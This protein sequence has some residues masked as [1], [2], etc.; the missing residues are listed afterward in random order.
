MGIRGVR[1]YVDGIP[2]TM[3]DGQGQISNVDLGSAAA[4][5]VLRGPFSALYGNSSGGVLQVFTEDGTGRS[6]LTLGIE[7]GSDGQLHYDSKLVGAQAG[8]DYVLSASHFET[9]GYREHSAARRDI[10]NAKLGIQLDDDSKLTV[11]ANA[12]QLP[13]AQD[14]MGLTRQELKGDPRGVDPSAVQFNTRKSLSQTQGG[15]IYERHFG[16]DNTLRALV[17]GGHRDTEQFQSIPAASQVN[18]LSPGGVIQ[19]GRDY[20]GTDVRWT[21]EIT[22]GTQR[23]SLVGRLAYDKLRE[24]RL[25]YQND[26]GTGSAQQLGLQGALRRDEINDVTDLDPY[27][28]VEWHPGAAWT[29][30][31]GVRHSRVRFISHDA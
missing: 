14:P 29:L 3:P 19:L 30:D 4:I 15:L 28:Q 23:W 11:V 6:K 17:Y 27:A 31:A 9:K 21:T 2:A 7:A 8:L 13:F 16:A 5:E 20:D 18:P 24:H 10:E 25:G 12:V 26:T 1:I 22:T